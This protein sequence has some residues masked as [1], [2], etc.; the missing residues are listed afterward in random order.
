MTFH[1]VHYFIGD[2]E[3]SVHSE[4]KNSAIHRIIHHPVDI[5]E[6]NCTIH[7]VQIYPVDSA[8]PPLNK[9]GRGNRPPKITL[10]YDKKKF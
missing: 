8:I 4:I 6:T 2:N 1:V 7:W 5:G 10:I 3:D 9:R